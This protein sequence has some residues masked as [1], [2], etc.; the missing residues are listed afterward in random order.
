MNFRHHSE[1]L[2]Q[3]RSPSDQSAPKGDITSDHI[4]IIYTIKGFPVPYVIESQPADTE[5]TLADF[6]AKAFPAKGDSR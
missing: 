1:Q 6:K 3:L 2:K 5:F 4:R